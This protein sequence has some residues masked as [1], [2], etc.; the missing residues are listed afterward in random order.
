MRVFL[1]GYMA[2]GKSKTG[3]QLAELLGLKHLDTDACIE[4]KTGQRV[5]EIF[6]GAGEDSFR[7]LEREVLDSL[8]RRRDIVVSTG[9]GLPCYGDNMERM[10][11]H[12]ITVYLEA[13]AGL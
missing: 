3:E 2:S 11:E 4:E 6:A 1:I 5:S 8:L 7:E 9:G 10:N 13:N 12:G